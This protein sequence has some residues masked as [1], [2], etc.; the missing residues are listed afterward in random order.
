VTDISLLNRKTYSDALVAS[1]Y[2]EA[3]G[4]Q[5]PEAQILSRLR[6]EFDGKRILDIGVGG[7]RTTPFLLEISENY[8]GIDYSPGMIERCRSRH[9]H[10]ELRVLDVRDLSQFGVNAFDLIFFSYNGIDYIEHEDRIR[11]LAQTRHSLSAGGAFVFSSHNRAAPAKS[12]WSL[13]HLPFRTSP[14]RESWPLA[15]Q[16]RRYATG[17]LNASVNK[18]YEKQTETY[19][20]RNDEAQQYSLITYYIHIEHQM[21][22]LE[23]AGYRDC[24]AVDLNG[25]WLEQR[26]YADIRDPWIYYLCRR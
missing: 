11:V 7:G 15:H 6:P 24:Q 25:R 5:L 19:E 2:G 4:L 9:P 1:E 3:T 20:L 17:L 18:R 10:V 12:A 26:D 14:F 21:R 13:D 23:D 8:V 16:L 22:Q